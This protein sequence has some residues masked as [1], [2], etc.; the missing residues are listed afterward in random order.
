MSPYRVAPDKEP[1]RRVLDAKCRKCG[2]WGHQILYFPIY[3]DAGPLCRDC[4]VEW[5]G[6]ALHWRFGVVGVGRSSWPVEDRWGPPSYSVVEI[7]GEERYESELRQ[8]L[9]RADWGCY[10]E[11]T[12][13]SRLISWFS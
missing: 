4:F 12:L 1:T 3:V 2:F 11:K 7:Y 6:L 13:L 10:E 8:P 9:I 5:R